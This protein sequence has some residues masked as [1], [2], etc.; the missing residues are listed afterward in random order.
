MFKK[1]QK[2]EKRLK[3]LN[4]YV[5]D[6]PWVHTGRTYFKTYFMPPILQ[7]LSFLIFGPILS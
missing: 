5:K 6:K 3:M 2:T 4:V 7:I 1:V